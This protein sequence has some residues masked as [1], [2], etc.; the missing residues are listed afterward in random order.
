MKLW[1]FVLLIA[2][3]FGQETIEVSVANN[4]A[5]VPVR[6]NERRLLFKLD[7]GSERSAMMLHS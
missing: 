7:T 6:V 4:V 5:L 3:A 2:C 1:L